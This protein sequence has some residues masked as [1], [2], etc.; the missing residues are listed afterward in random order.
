MAEKNAEVEAIRQEVEYTLADVPDG[1]SDAPP[2]GLADRLD[3]LAEMAEDAE[4]D[5]AP[6]EGLGA[7]DDPRQVEAAAR[8]QGYLRQY[9]QTQARG[10]AANYNPDQPRHPAG[11]AG[12]GRFAPASGA[13]V[14]VGEG[15]TDGPRAA[16]RT[17]GRSAPRQGVA[18]R[19][20]TTTPEPRTPAARR[21][22]T[23]L[24]GYKEG[25]AARQALLAGAAKVEE[26][27][28]KAADLNGRLNKMLDGFQALGKDEAK[29]AAWR[30][31]NGAAFKDLTEQWRGADAAAREHGAGLMAKALAQTD[32]AP[33]TNE[34]GPLKTDAQRQ[35]LAGGL[36]WLDGKV[37]RDVLG[38]GLKVEAVPITAGEQR[39][40]YDRGR[41][42]LSKTTNAATVVHEVGH[43]LNDVPHVMEMAGAFWEHRFGGEPPTKM[44][45]VCKSCGYDRDEVGR[46]DDMGKVFGTDENR[47]YYAGKRYSDGQTELVSMGLEELHRDPVK[48]AKADPEYFHF[49]H[50]VLSG[51]RLP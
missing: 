50:A 45:S 1:E 10:L 31:K 48:V 29:E 19:G 35:A 11:T 34:S 16:A 46:K 41:V 43:Q 13:G 26:A 25:E 3:V 51:K 4:A 49:L 18:S 17:R 40:Y 5:A 22:A 47:A 2:P 24:A 6:D 42:F 39:A 23:F 20:E 36:E 15:T 32:P 7:P 9:L 8:V 21:V 33:V 30:E 27:K 37:S 28:A 12:G 38:G 44:I 14:A